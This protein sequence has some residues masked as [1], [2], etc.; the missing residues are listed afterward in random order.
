MPPECVTHNDCDINIMYSSLQG[1]ATIKGTELVQ[2]F[3]PPTYNS[4]NDP[5]WKLLLDDV[6]AHI[7]GRH[8]EFHGEVAAEDIDFWH[9]GGFSVEAVH[10][11]CETGISATVKGLRS[12][13]VPRHERT[14]AAARAKAANKP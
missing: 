3:G 10:K 1:Y 11:L 5:K 14:K 4:A 7:Y 13:C 9:V 8:Y 12:R 6:V 2:R